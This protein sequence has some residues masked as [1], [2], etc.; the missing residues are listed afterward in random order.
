MKYLTIINASSGYHN[1]K[2]DKM[3]SYLT[4]CLFDLALTDNKRYI[5]L[6][7]GAVPTRNMFQVKIDE[8]F[9]SISNEFRISDDILIASFS[10]CGKNHNKTSQ[11]VLQVC[12]QVNLKLNK[13]KC[14][15][16]CT[17]IPLFCEILSKLGV[18]LKP[19]TVQALTDVPLLKTTKEFISG[20]NKLAK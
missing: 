19:R 11:K 1:L 20:Y 17:R 16:R 15:F 3:S 13:D 10:E 9:S 6:P 12:R 7:F 18:N 4:V 5:R 8:L 2:L 14:I